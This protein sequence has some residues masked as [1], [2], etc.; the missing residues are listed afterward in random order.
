MMQ[1]ADEFFMRLALEEARLAYEEG[2]VPIGAVLV[3]RD[4][5]VSRAHNQTERLSD[6]T[7]H[8]E[9]LCVSAASSHLDMKYLPECRLYVTIEPCAMCAGAIRWSRVAEVIYGAS[10]EKFGYHVYSEAIIPRSCKVRGGVLEHD[11]R[12]LMQEFFQSKRK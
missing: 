2:E 4:R 6:P 10:E 5:V 12:A 7:A 11:A 8:A 3:H 1:T 9:V